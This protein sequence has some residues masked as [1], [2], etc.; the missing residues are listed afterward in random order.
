MV[1][2]EQRTGLIGSGAVSV[3]VLVEPE[4]TEDW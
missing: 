4:A 3:F 1:M 2:N